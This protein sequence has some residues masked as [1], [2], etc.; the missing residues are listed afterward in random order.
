MKMPDDKKVLD[1]AAEGD[2]SRFANSLC[3]PPDE[4]PAVLASA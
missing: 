2:Q 3:Q 4:A 1:P